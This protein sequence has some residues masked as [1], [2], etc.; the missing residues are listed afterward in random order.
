[1]KDEKPKIEYPFH[2]DEFY[3]CW[4]RWK[5]YKK[6]EWRFYYKSAISEQSAL[7]D[8][9]KISNGNEHTAIDIIGQ[10]LAKG[11]QGLFPIKNNNNG[12][13]QTVGNKQTA[14]TYEL[15]ERLRNASGAN[16][17]GK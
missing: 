17:T 14:G 10:S 7:D 4:N 11:W 3:Q 2:S 13:G 9:R 12:N 5:Q 15:L 6:E 16:R 8:L 1:M